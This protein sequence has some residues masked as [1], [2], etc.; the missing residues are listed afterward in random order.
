LSDFGLYFSHYHIPVVFTKQYGNHIWVEVALVGGGVLTV[1]VV[2]LPN[3]VVETYVVKVAET[4]VFDAEVKCFDV[5]DIHVVE[6]GNAHGFPPPHRCT[7]GDSFSR[8]CL[9]VF[10]LVGGELGTQ[11]SLHLLE[12]QLQ[13]QVI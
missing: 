11:H 12:E 3:S 4:V 6:Q 10:N 1:F 5:V 13:I 7:L 2:G 9:E 8:E